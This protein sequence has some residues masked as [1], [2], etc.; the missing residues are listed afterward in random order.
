MTRAYVWK[1]EGSE[2]KELVNKRL[3]KEETSLQGCKPMCK[4]D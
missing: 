2:I 3:K 1:T 4:D